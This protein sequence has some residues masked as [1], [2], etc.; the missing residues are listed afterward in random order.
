[1]DVAGG[2]QA[3]GAEQAKKRPSPAQ[4]FKQFDTNGDGKLAGSELD[5]VPA[6]IRDQLTSADTNND[7]SIELSELGAALARMRA[8]GGGPPADRSGGGE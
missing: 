5:T 4:L 6:A 3:P 2:K 1:M 7:G 8:A